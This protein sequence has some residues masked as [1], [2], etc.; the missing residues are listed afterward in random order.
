MGIYNSVLELIGK[1]PIVRLKKIDK[2]FTGELY[3]K[4][5]SFNPGSSIKDRVALNMIDNAEQEGLL[6]PRSEIVEA[7]SGN[8]GIGLAIVCASKGYSLTI[9]MPESVSLER[10]QI[11]KTLGA[12]VI[13]TPGSEGMKGAIK[14]ALEIARKNDNIFLPNQFRNSH[15]PEIHRKTTALEIWNDMNQRLDTVIIGVGT[16]GTITGIGEALKR[17][18][19]KIK[20][21]AVEP[22]GS[23]M[24]SKGKKGHHNIPGIG[25]GFIPEVLNTDIIDRIITIN[26]DEAL[27]SLKLLA[28]K[29][30][31]FVGI[32]SGAVLA[33]ALKYCKEII[34]NER[35]VMVF[36]DTGERY[37]SQLV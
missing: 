7:T 17:L 18:D 31:I 3:A 25:P 22:A 26:D 5:E 29:E 9:I 2:E 23:P 4:I 37:L 32:S 8:T 13:L 12:T 30:G 35:I 15:N 6:H 28:R 27:G 20:I 11:L 16:G 1:T 21:I 34:R 10:Q 14:K 33:A 24:L 36:P 19:P